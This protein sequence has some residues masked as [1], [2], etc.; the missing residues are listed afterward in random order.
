MAI[1]DVLVDAIAKI[2]KA[3]REET[4]NAFRAEIETCL[5][6]MDELRQKFDA[7]PSMEEG[8]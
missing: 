5:K 4:D 6:V 7:P 3:L 8:E 1:S 2:K